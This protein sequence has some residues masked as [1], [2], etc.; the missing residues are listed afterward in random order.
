MRRRRYQLFTTFMLNSYKW[1]R[2]SAVKFVPLYG[3]LGG[4]PQWL[5]DPATL[6]RVS[7]P[8]RPEQSTVPPSIGLTMRFGFHH[9]NASHSVPT[10]PHSRY[11]ADVIC[12]GVFR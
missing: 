6:A 4:S 8:R 7:A 10:R 5:V 12:M 2:R 9:P 1:L 3:C 11:R